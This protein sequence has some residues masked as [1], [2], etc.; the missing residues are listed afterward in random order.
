MPGKLTGPRP[1][2]LS[3]IGERIE[4]RLQLRFFLPLLI[5]A[6]ATTWYGLGWSL[7]RFKTLTGGQRFVDMQPQL[8]VEQL[9]AQFS[10][11][12]A[13]TVRF[14]LWWSLFDYAW[15]FLTFTTML[16]IS[17]WL[18]S[19]L[20]PGWRRAFPL[21]IASAYLT[22]ACDWTENLG[23]VALLLGRPA[24]PAWLAGLTLSLH[25]G[26]LAFNMV[27]NLTFWVVLIAAGIA[28]IERRRHR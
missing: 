20:P 28:G 19:R 25:A 27:F 13:P 8:T 14:Y 3:R 18:V 22:V 16:F 15:P 5:A 1:G 23:F 26:K 21:L 24:Q 4:Q 7:A 2:L 10:A 12:D 6:L 9:F 11:Y 17:A